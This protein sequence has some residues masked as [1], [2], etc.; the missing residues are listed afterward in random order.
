MYSHF[1]ELYDTPRFPDNKMKFLRFA[2]RRP[3]ELNRLW[4]FFL[5]YPR[6]SQ[7]QGTSFSIILLSDLHRKN[8]ADGGNLS[9]R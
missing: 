1:A 2:P 5:L 7:L 6:P 3:F 9:D 4:I 8:T